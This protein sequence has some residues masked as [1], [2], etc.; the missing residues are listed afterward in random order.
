MRI[1]KIVCVVFFT[2]ASVRVFITLK[3]YLSGGWGGMCCRAVQG[4]YH[5]GSWG[6]GDATALAWHRNSM[7]RVHE[8]HAELPLARRVLH[9]RALSAGVPRLGGAARLCPE[10]GSVLGGSCAGCAHDLADN[11]FP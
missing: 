8:P 7:F 2:S 11:A 4:S 1:K 10:L 9:I 6:T 3:A 5:W